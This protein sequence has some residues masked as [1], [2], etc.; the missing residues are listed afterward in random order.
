M[1]PKTESLFF[2]MVL[3]L[4][5]ACGSA[6][7]DPFSADAPLPPSVSQ[8]TAKGQMRVLWWNILD[9]T[10]NR[11]A[12]G[13]NLAAM[14]AV[15]HPPDVIVLGEYHRDHGLP[16]SANTALKALY[17]YAR[18]FPYSSDFP[19]KGIYVLSR[20]PVTDVAYQRDALDWTP[21]EWSQKQKA[22]YK[23]PFYRADQN[24]TRQ[25]QRSYIRLTL[26]W[27][28]KRVDIAPVHTA[29]P[30]MV[31]KAMAGPIGKA[32]V[33]ADITFGK[34]NPLIYQ[35]QRLRTELKQ[36][37]GIHVSD[38][39]LVL[40]DFNM[41]RA[42]A[43]PL[44]SGPYQI[45]KAGFRD[46][47]EKASTLPFWKRLCR[48][49]FEGLAPQ[50]VSFPTVEGREKKPYGGLLNMQLDHAFAKHSA[51]SAEVLPLRG[52]DHYPILVDISPQ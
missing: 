30:W 25:W 12:L 17:P 45:M 44:P 26:D 3:S 24:E 28:G 9:G 40:G 49:V 34:K 13:Q 19:E 43:S 37:P 4:L 16:E 18:F 21:A 6:G 11:E 15:S 10:F 23:R 20:V 52:S 27:N 36:D 42:L 51:G 31:M 22:G 5:L 2:Y 47:F 8:P 41:P 48:T 14:T 39:L 7:A 46:L 32:T 50:N 1:A 35:L 29:M 38:P 33:A